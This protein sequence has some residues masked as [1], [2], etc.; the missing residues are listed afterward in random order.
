MKMDGVEEGNV[1]FSETTA[2]VF[3]YTAS[4]TI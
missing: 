4:Q 1:P 3:A 2:S